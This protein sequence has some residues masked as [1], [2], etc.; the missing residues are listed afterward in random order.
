MQ[1]MGITMKQ[2]T[3][4]PNSEARPYRADLLRAAKAALSLTNDEIRE[5]TGLSV[6]TIAN[7]LRGGDKETPTTDTLNLLCGSL[8]L[9]MS[10]LFT[11][12]QVIEVVNEM[13]YRKPEIVEA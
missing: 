5:A 1:I 13:P 7:A 9:K 2:E 10:D 12:R 4:S 3:S 8:G 6:S 11:E